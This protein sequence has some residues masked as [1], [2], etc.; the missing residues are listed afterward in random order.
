MFVAYQVL[1]ANEFSGIENSDGSIE[2]CKKPSKN[3]KSSKDLKLSKSRNLKSENLCK[4][5]KS[6]KLGKKLSKSGN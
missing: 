5:Q 4:S 2:K 6:A 3:R 1:A